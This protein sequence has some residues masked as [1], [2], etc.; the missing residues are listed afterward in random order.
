[1]SIM[2]CEKCGA[3]GAVVH[4]TQIVDNQMSTH[5]LCERCAA[6]KGLETA[7]TASD[8]PLMDVIAQMAEASPV[9]TSVSGSTCAFCGLTWRDFR[10]TGRLG[11]PHCWETFGSEIPRLLRRVHGAAA[12]AG[13]IYLPPDPSASEMEKRLEGLRRRLEHAVHAE[14]FERAAELRDQIRSLGPA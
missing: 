3:T 12:H 11:C 8:L 13:K 6:E 7:P 9:D 5:H 14:D 2:I 10:K 4:L 1:M